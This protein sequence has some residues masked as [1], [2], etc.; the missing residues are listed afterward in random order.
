[1]DRIDTAKDHWFPS[2]NY[3][4]GNRNCANM[5]WNSTCQASFMGAY[6]YPMLNIVQLCKPDSNHLK[7]LRLL[8][9]QRISEWKKFR[10][11]RLHL[12]LRTGGFQGWIKV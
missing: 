8:F 10:A 1:M 3:Q 12:L 7:P 9:F 2:T 4:P 5:D 11:R 6:W